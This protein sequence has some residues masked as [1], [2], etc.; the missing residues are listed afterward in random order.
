MT[1]CLATVSSDL[2][3]GKAHPRPYSVHGLEVVAQDLVYSWMFPSNSTSE[4]P[5]ILRP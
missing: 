5:R 3:I 2:N 1:T 4:L